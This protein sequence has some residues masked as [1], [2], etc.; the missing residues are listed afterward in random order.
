MVPGPTI[1][2]PIAI[3]WMMWSEWRRKPSL[4]LALDRID[5]A[6]AVNCSTPPRYGI[7]HMATVRQV[8]TIPKVKVKYKLVN[9]VIVADVGLSFA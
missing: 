5:V 2:W 3:T 7:D 1:V 6:A 4:P 9:R 8:L